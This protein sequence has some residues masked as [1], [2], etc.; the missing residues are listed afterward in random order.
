MSD[1]V[2][3]RIGERHGFDSGFG[4]GFIAGMLVTAIITGCFWMLVMT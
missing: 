3:Y 1:N 4:Y 2:Y